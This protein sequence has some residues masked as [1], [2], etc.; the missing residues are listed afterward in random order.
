[1]IAQR[2]IRTIT[3]KKGL[4]TFVVVIVCLAYVAIEL[5]QNQGDPLSFVIYDGHYSYQISIGLSE[6]IGLEVDSSQLTYAYKNERPSAY[7]YQRILYPLI[8]WSLALGSPHRV[9][10]TLIFV[11]VF[12]IGIGTWITECILAKL[13]TSHWYALVY[14]LYSGQLI[15]LRSDMNE[16][17]AQ[18]LIQFAIWAWMKKSHRWAALGLAL[19]LF[20]K[21][22]AVLFLGAFILSGILQRNWRESLGYGAA[23][24][25]Y[26]LFQVSLRYLI[27]ESG[28]LTGQ[29]FILTPFGGWL[30]SAQIHFGAFLLISL[31]IVPM[32]IIPT[33]FGIALSA[34]KLWQRAYHP[35]ILSLLL[36]SVF[37]LFLP[38]LTFR[39]SSAMARVTQGL[40]VS[41]LLFGAL[42]KSRRVL[43]YS[44]LWLFSSVIVVNG[45]T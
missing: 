45:I 44:Q 7:R 42:I 24:I 18:A 29:P 21:E 28:L 17:L 11:N 16:P 27:G 2:L 4:P 31:V 35:F 19:A 39:E 30:Q 3:K 32:S 15:A 40:M 36:N 13:N 14:G 9:L 43:N 8:S 10:W 22:T 12:F 26:G 34:I 5:V 25:P 6:A 20:A 38:H 41:M 37:I 1:M 23:L 33:L